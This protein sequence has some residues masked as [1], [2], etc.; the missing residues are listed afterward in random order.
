[1]FKLCQLINF[2]YF[3]FI[4]QIDKLKAEKANTPN[5]NTNILYKYLI[6]KS[7]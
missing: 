5:R 3:Y 7:N 4:Q 2:S 6:K 1:M